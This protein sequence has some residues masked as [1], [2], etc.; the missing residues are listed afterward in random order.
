M[1]SHIIMWFSLVFYLFIILVKILVELLKISITFFHSQSCWALFFVNFLPLYRQI[2]EISLLHSLNHFSNAS[3]C[4][5]TVYYSSY[6]SILYDFSI[7]CKL[8]ALNHTRELKLT[9]FK[10]IMESIS[11]KH[12][13]ETLFISISIYKTSNFF[14]ISELK[15]N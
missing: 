3:I 5:F 15:T 10:R 11:I 7:C 14:R 8:Y 12:Q 13:H 2:Y 6:S 1:I 4:I 9:F